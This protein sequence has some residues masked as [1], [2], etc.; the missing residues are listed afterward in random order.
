MKLPFVNRRPTKI[1][2]V[3]RVMVEERETSRDGEN[4]KTGGWH[5]NTVKNELT[6][7]LKKQK[8]K[9]HTDRYV[10]RKSSEKQNV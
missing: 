10:T 5:C 8:N 6:I 9:R 2:G 3:D 1:Q 4:L 7:Y